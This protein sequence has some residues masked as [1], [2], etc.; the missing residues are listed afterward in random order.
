MTENKEN[1]VLTRQTVDL[2]T[3]LMEHFDRIK[4][5]RGFRSFS[6]YAVSLIEADQQG[7]IKPISSDSQ[8]GTQPDIDTVAIRI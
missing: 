1:I 6:A 7:L 5:R 4:R 3:D 2:P 8:I